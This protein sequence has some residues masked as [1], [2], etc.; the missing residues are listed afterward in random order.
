MSAWYQS[1]STILPTLTALVS[2]K[3]GVERNTGTDRVAV[4][5]G[6]DTAGLKLVTFITQCA[7]I[8]SEVDLM[9]CNKC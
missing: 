4:A 5:V 9:G 3:T 1:S 6:L 7:I 2:A 8:R